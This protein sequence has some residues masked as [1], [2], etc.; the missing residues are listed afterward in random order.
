MSGSLPL[1]AGSRFRYRQFY[2]MCSFCS[3]QLLNS[4][5]FCKQLFFGGFVL[6]NRLYGFFLNFC[7]L[8]GESTRNP[9]FGIH[10]FRT[11][12]GSGNSSQPA[13][14]C[15]ETEV[16]FHS[17][18]LPLQ[19]WLLFYRESFLYS[20]FADSRTMYVLP[21]LLK[22]TQAGRRARYEAV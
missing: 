6:A 16:S 15:W 12:P 1:Q 13:S 10:S 14:V 9:L 2:R 18:A 4:G 22:V 5:C 3:R 19:A 11:I 8:S 20:V 7:L 21:G 17:S